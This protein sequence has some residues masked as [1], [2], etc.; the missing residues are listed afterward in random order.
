MLEK[1]VVSVNDTVFLEKQLHHFHPRQFFMLL[2]GQINVILAAYH[3][4]HQCSVNFG[5]MS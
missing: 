3:F 2:R 5:H 1:S 4:N